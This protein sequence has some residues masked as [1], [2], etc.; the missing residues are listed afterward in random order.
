MTIEHG[1]HNIHSTS[2]E[3][4][5]IQPTSDTTG[6]PRSGRLSKAA[7]FAVVAAFAS[8]I[9]ENLEPP[10]GDNIVVQ[11]AITDEITTRPP[12]SEIK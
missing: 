12:S 4:Q 9:H 2:T 11:S 3:V 1:S 8:G 5:D 6:D 7:R 10:K